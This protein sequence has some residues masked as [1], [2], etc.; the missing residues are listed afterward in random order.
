VVDE[1]ERLCPKFF[2]PGGAK[3]MMVGDMLLAHYG[4]TDM[5][6]YVESSGNVYYRHLRSLNP[7]RVGSAQD[8]KAGAARLQ[9]DKLPGRY[10]FPWQRD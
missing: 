5:R 6:L 9:C 10:L 2:P 3:L 4:G 7:S 8:L 1:V